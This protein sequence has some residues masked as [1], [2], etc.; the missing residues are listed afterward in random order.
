MRSCFDECRRVTAID[1]GQLV[2]GMF[3]GPDT[4]SFC[5]EMANQRHEQRGFAGT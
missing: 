5:Y 2:M 3:D 1:R 4:P